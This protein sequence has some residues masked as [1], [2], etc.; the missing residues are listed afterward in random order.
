MGRPAA[1]RSAFGVVPGSRAPWK[2]PLVW[3]QGA[4]GFW[5]IGGLDGDL[6]P[7]SPSRARCATPH[8]AEP[9]VTPTRT[10][11]RLRPRGPWTWDLKVARFRALVVGGRCQR[12]ARTPCRMA[13]TA[14]SG[15][16]ISPRDWAHRGRF[17]IFLSSL[18]RPCGFPCSSWRQFR[19]AVWRRWSGSSSSFAFSR[20]RRT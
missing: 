11:A 20:L 2:G 15:G 7:M 18:P 17:A 5:G 14:R 4:T 12:E 19:S 8:W 16:R 13:H 1:A 10:R 3:R 9:R 6:A